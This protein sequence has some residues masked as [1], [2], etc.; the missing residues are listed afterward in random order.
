MIVQ[1]ASASM[2]D[3][4][5]EGEEATKWTQA[6]VAIA[7][8]MEKYKTHIHFGLDV[9]PNLVAGTDSRA[10]VREGCKISD[11]VILDVAD[12][13]LENINEKL[14]EIAIAQVARTPLWKEMWNFVD[15]T[16]APVFSN[17]KY[18]S[19]L[20]VISDGVDTCKPEANADAG[21]EEDTEETGLFNRNRDWLEGAT[22]EQL[23]NLSGR[24]A[25]NGIKTFVIGF[26]DDISDPVQL[27]AI[28]KNGGTGLDTHLQAADEKALAQQLTDV[29][30]KVISCTYEIGQ[31]DKTV[32][33][34]QANFFFDGKMVGRDDDCA[35]GKGWT[36]TDDTMTTV[37]FCDVACEQLKK[38]KIAKVTAQ[39]GCPSVPVY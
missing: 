26:G 35:K 4:L 24:L 39:F 19:Y 33:V 3:K 38:G 30:Y 31:Q 25:N 11:P 7:D 10:D 1:D 8:V 2:R 36:L 6:K 9:F 5:K 14:A 29:I 13:N 27:D 34:D 21:I 22:A 23:G 28:A 12:G 16:Y 32:D 18:D 37:K 15:K 17:G 20:L